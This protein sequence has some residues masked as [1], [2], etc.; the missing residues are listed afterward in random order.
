MLLAELTFRVMQD[1]DFSRAEQAIRHYIEALIFNGQTLGR[2]V[3]TAFVQDRFC[4]RVVIPDTDA[5][6]NN[7]HSPRGLIAMQQ[8]V[9]AGLAYPELSIIGQDL[10]S[11]HTDPCPDS[12]FYILFTSFADTCSPLR[13][14]EH[15]APVPLYHVKTEHA[16]HEALIRWQLQYQA[17]D[18]I[19]MQQQRV[20]HKTAEN[21]L[22]QLNSKL[23]RQGRQFAS[24]AEQQLQRPV[25]YYLYSGS[26]QNCNAEADRCCPSCGQAWKRATPLHQL[27]DFQCQPCR[28]VSNIAWECQDNDVSL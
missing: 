2:E 10:M 6:D 25:F 22:Q 18:E 23:N 20:L 11:N 9:N 24:Q 3:P 19:Q 8:L 27:F 21:S 5:L 16:D 4:S 28:L 13:C 15:F 7:N 26:S 17:L 14:G 1:T 12:P